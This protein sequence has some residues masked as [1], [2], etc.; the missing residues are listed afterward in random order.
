[1]LRQGRPGL[2]TIASILLRDAGFAVAF[3]ESFINRGQMK[4]ITTIFLTGNL[5]NAVLDSL[6]VFAALLLALDAR[7]PRW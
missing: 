6:F 7:E 3:M 2:P 5:L 4:V 1:M